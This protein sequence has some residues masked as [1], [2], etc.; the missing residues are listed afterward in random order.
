M[1]HRHC[2]FICF[3]IRCYNLVYCNEMEPK[4]TQKGLKTLFF[5]I[6]SQQQPYWEFLNWEESY[7]ATSVPFC[8]KTRFKNG[9]EAKRPLKPDLHET[10]FFVQS[11]FFTANAR[12]ICAEVEIRKFAANSQPDCNPTSEQERNTHFTTNVCRLLT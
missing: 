6:S 2:S 4:R 7:Q 3:Q 12:K 11:E 9:I 5:R 1:N 8:V 10:N